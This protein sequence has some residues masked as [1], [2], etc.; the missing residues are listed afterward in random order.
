LTGLGIGVTLS[1]PTR[2]EK[3]LHVPTPSVGEDLRRSPTRH[4]LSAVR[5]HRGT[6]GS[7]PSQRRVCCESNFLDQ[8]RRSVV[9]CVLGQTRA[10]IIGII[11]HWADGSFSNLP[12]PAVQCEMASFVGLLR[13][14]NFGGTGKLTM[15]SDAQRNVKH[16]S[17]STRSMIFT[18]LSLCWRL[19]CRVRRRRRLSG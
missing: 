18:D 17:V 12:D 16:A 10:D 19:P 3:S 8:W 4:G 1:S 7:F 9:Y 2:C 11:A 15:S 13:A 5:A 6:E 14:V